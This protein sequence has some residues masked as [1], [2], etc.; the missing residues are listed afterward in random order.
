MGEKDWWRPA[1]WTKGGVIELHFA[2]GG[3]TKCGS[4]FWRKEKTKEGEC[5]ELHVVEQQSHLSSFRKVL[6]CVYIF[7]FGFRKVFFF[8]VFIVFFVFIYFLILCW[9]GK[10]WEFQRFRFYIYNN[11]NNNILMNK[12]FLKI[13]FKFNLKWFHFIVFKVLLLCGHQTNE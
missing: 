9:R 1:F 7:I 3:T 2:C 6:F 11:N 4:A 8:F 13:Y 10:L 12:I 5:R